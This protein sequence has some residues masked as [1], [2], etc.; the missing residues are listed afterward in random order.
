MMALARALQAR[1]HEAVF[2]GVPDIAPIVR[3]AG[4]VFVPCGEAEYPPGSVARVWGPVAHLQGLETLRY[5]FEEILP[6]FLPATLRRLPIARAFAEEARLAID[7]SQ[8][9]VTGS[10]L[11]VITQTPEIFDF[12]GEQWPPQ[13]HYAGPLP[14]A[15]ARATVPF[16]WDRLDGSSARLRVDGHAGE[17]LGAGAAGDPGC[18]GAAGE[19]PGRVLGRRQRRPGRARR[20]PAERDRGSDGAAARAC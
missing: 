9:D 7:W 3:P 17:R 11:A 8:P 4:L 5:A 18:G 15:N 6:D 13:F 16:V 10:G 2:I 14:D 19:P 20:H 12:T 1:G